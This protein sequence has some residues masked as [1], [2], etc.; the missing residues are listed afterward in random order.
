MKIGALIGLVI[1]TSVC[2]S[3]PISLILLQ[4]THR[5][6]TDVSVHSPLGCYITIRQDSQ[7]FARVPS[8][9][10]EPSMSRRKACMYSPS[11]ART[12]MSSNFRSER[13]SGFSHM[14][15]SRDLPVQFGC[16]L[17]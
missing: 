8:L 9:D 14:Q 11:P 7:F 2:F 15:V 1:S 6:P 5:G 10:S 4:S 13:R 17:F 12:I 16:E 3:Y